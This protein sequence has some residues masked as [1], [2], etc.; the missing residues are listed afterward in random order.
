M[1][2]RCNQ[3]RNGGRVGQKLVKKESGDFVM[4]QKKILLRSPER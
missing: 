1:L 2:C 4:T 3:I